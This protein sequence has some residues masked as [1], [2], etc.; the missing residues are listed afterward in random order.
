M[1][2]LV[3]QA[4]ELIYKMDADQVDQIVEAIKLKRTHLAKTVA[5][6]IIIGDIVSFD[7]RRGQTVTGKVTKVNQKTVVVRDSTTQIQW[8]VTASMLTK[9]G[10]GA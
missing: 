6:S 7:G 2:N 8:K 10:I 9:L 3:T 1:S 5:R 4:S